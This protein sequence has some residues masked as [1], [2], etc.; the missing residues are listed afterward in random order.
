VAEPGDDAVSVG[1]E[2]VSS[3]DWNSKVYMRDI[4]SKWDSLIKKPGYGTPRWRSC[5]KLAETV[6]QLLDQSPNPE[7]NSCVSFA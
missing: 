4:A 6:G 7:P 2:E 1:I 5:C 3:S